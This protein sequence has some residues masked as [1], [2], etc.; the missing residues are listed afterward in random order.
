MSVA[1]EPEKLLR[2]LRKLWEG[3][4]QEQKTTGGA[5][6]SVS[7]TLLVEATDESDANA[8]RVVLSK[9]M[10]DHPSRA[11]VIRM[12]DGASSEGRVFSQC[13]MPGG[14]P[15]QVCAEGV[16]LALDRSRMEQ[17]IP[18]VTP[19]I[20]PDLPVVLWRRGERAFGG[21]GFAQLYPLAGKI[22][23][24]SGAAPDP[25]AAVE[26]LRQ[27]KAHG[28]TVAD[29]AWTR[30]TGWREAL[31]QCFDCDTVPLRSI[32]SAR[33][34]HEG[35]SAPSCA[36]YFAAWIEGSLPGVQM[37]LESSGG[38]RRLNEPGLR[39][40]TLSGSAGEIGI[41][42]APGGGAVTIRAAGC[43]SRSLLPPASEDEWMR[44]E[45]KILGAD[46]VFNRVLG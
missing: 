30:L 41:S 14:Q 1:L 8:V 35:K 24:D 10:R 17:L 16:D 11:I 37:K 15:R 23:F 5:L 9:I 29:L 13:W 31:A 2:E 6:R 20:V 4:D 45:L 28:H 21:L 19:L 22:I 36:L 40:V 25:A 38:E 42:L 34:V 3:L 33:I 44:E 27:L 18:W 39:E 32:Q 43:D 12:I 46:P 7:M 26:F